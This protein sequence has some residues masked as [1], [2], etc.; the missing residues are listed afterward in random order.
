M[1]LEISLNAIG[2]TNN[3][4]GWPSSEAPRCNPGKAGARLPPRSPDSRAVSICSSQ[5]QEDSTQTNP[6]DAIV[7]VEETRAGDEGTRRSLAH[8]APTATEQEITRP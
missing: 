2:L 6:P 7:G 8:R 4:T 5:P 1:H 3:P